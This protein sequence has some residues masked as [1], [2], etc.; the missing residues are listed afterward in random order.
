MSQNDTPT[1]L[2]II[3]I[4]GD[5]SKRRLLPA[6]EQI[7]KAKAAPSKF[8]VVGISR[9]KIDPSIVLKD[10]RT[11]K[12]LTFLSNNL[13]MHQMDLT[14][15]EDYD[16][17]KSHLLILEQQLGGSSQWLFYLSIPPQFTNQ[18]IKYLGASGISSH[19]STKLLVEKPFGTDLVS[20]KELIRQTKKSFLEEQIY[21]IDHYLAKEM[22]QNLLVFRSGNPLF[23][24]TWNRDFIE[25]IEIIAGEKIDIEDRA[26]FYEQT[27]AL[28]DLVQSHL[29]QLTALTLMEIPRKL[30][31]RDVPRLKK[32][33]LKKLHLPNEEAAKADVK[34][35]QYEGYR[36][37]VDNPKSNVET[38]LDITLVS[39]YARWQGVPIRLIT[40]KALS[41]KTTQIRI[42]YK[43]DENYESNVLIIRM[44]PNEGVTFQLWTKMPGYAWRVE[45]RS[46]ELGFKEE[47]DVLP[48]A[49]ERVILDAINS[50]HTFFTGSGEVLESWRIL[51]P[52]QKS[53]SMTDKD[54][55]FY[56]KGTNVT[57]LSGVEIK[58]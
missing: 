8:K 19:K 14:R 29:L 1:I 2:V 35:G 24:R 58:A 57:E 52:I 34:R 13:R 44:Q 18:V 10:A 37:E 9:S 7:V 21:R 40:G 30:E 41:E 48:E 32:N 51:E 22:A 33:T 26:V 45:S 31:L 11:S 4:T 6:V 55:F 39:D 36:K 12:P 43:S 42:I 38:Y 25:R 17:L 15:P 46:L 27:G 20:A 49:Y 56:K 3:G 16:N 28:R 50:D 47:T 23:K 54:L 53:W 5:L